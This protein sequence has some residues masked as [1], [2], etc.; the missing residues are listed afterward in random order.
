MH[1]HPSGN[2]HPSGADIAETRRIASLLE[3]LDLRLED[4]LIVSGNAIFS[5]RGAMLI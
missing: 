2:V 4:H 1:N 5:M 3:N